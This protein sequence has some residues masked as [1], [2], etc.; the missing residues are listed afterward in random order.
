MLGRGKLVTALLLP[1]A[2]ILWSIGWIFY[3]FGSRTAKPIQER[4]PTKMRETEA[5]ENE[6]QF[7]V[8]SPE[9][10]YAT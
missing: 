3:W 9:P 8:V 6:L 4:P 2:V 10:Q 7:Q 5:I 1:V